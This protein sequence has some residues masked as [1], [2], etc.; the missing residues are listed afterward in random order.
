MKYRPISRLLLGAFLVLSLAAPTFAASS[1]DAQKWLEKLI[2]IYDRGPFTVDYEA[3]LDL[4]GLG[5]PM[6]GAMV[7]KLTQ[8]DRTHSRMEVKL[9][10][11]GAPGM[12]GGSMSM[13]ILTI[14]DGTTVWS[15]MENPAF[16]GPQI[17]KVS[18][19]ELAEV[20]ET[21]GGGGLGGP[22]SMDP[23]AQ[24]EA[25]TQTMDFE[26]LERA[27]DT[28]TL[29]GTITEEARAKMG[30]MAPPGVNAFLIV[31][32][33]KTG[34]PTQVRADGENPFVTINFR[35]LE[36]V[37]AASLPAGLF[38]YSP[39]AGVPVKDLGPMLKSHVR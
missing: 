18:L 37:D 1:P 24:L 21:F 3:K 2:T 17:T 9:D 23:V 15:E 20:G 8:A 10:L 7:G 11:A 28:V 12:P 36:F 33:E 31:L 22:T 34:F 27:G 29:R 13:S 38:E 25:L 5:Q 26:V 35:D 32:D 19:T 16:G 39:P 30:M 4:A 14:T 6:S